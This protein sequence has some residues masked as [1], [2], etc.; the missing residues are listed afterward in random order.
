MFHDFDHNFM[1]GDEDKYSPR[2]SET[3]WNR[4]TDICVDVKT[5]LRR[6]RITQIGKGYPGVLTRDTDGHYQFVETLPS[7]AAKRNPHVY[8]GAY[9]TIT[10]RDDGSFRPNFKPMRMNE[11]FSVDSYAIGVMNELREAFKGLVEEEP[12]ER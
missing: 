1:A 8:A 2:H 3:S 9:I 10:R 7:L 4:N 11:C 12:A 5:F 6:D